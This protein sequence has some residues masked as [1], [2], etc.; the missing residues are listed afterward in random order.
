MAAREEF[1][2]TLKRN[3]FA[4][5][6]ASA[7]LKGDREIVLEAVKQDGYALVYASAEL[8][9]DREIVM[10]AV[11]QNGRALQ[12]ASAELQGDREIVLEAVKQNGRALRY[13]SP[14]LRNGELK[15]Y[16]EALVRSVFNVPRQT[17]IA[18]ILFG[19]KSLPSPSSQVSSSSSSSSGEGG[20]APP[21]STRSRLCDNSGCFLS[22]LR[23]STV[24]PGALSTVVK[25]LIW[26]YAGVRS[27]GRFQSIAQVA[28]TLQVRCTV[29]AERAFDVGKPLGMK[30]SPDARVTGGTDG[31]QAAALGV[32]VGEEVRAVDGAPVASLAELKG[33]M[34]AIKIKQQQMCEIR[35]E[36]DEVL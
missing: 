27:G 18:T 10:A 2:K 24:L 29:A 33:H 13:A 4:L 7:E 17:F 20:G 35:F 21:P 14:A 23:P 32:A 25:R 15:V 16:V 1:L 26:D 9:G 19:A 8:K 31:G 11:K 12:Y 3:P 6:Y 5:E 36:W 34:K 22:L 30:I 28:R